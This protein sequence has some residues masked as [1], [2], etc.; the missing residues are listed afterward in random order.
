MDAIAQDATY[1]FEDS[2]TV[3]IDG[4][5]ARS[6]LPEEQR[7]SEEQTPHDLLVGSGGLKGFPETNANTMAL[8]LQSLVN[9][10][11]FLDHIDIVLRQLADP[12]KIFDCLLTATA[13]KEPTR[14]FPDEVA[15][16]KQETRRN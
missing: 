7:T 9:G 15:T 1:R 8:F 10:T 2:R 12:A 14:R 13:S 11:N 5:D 4:I 6:V 3:I 16:N